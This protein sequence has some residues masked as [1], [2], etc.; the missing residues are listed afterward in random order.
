ML[1]AALASAWPYI[2]H[3]AVMGNPWATQAPQ[4]AANAEPV[5]LPNAALESEITEEP[6]AAASA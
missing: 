3:A 1:P 4:T 5:Y 2:P 6:E